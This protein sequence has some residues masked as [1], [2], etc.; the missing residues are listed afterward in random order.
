M[1][2]FQLVLLRVKHLFEELVHLALFVAAR[3]LFMMLGS[4][5]FFM[6]LGPTMLLCA[7]TTP[8]ASTTSTRFT[9]FTISTCFT[10]HLYNNPIFFY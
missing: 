6:V 8:F 2:V 10:R 4:V 5:M 3:V 7:T 1:K 9:I